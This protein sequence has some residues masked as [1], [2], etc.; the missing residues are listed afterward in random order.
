M[1]RK[2][3]M[4]TPAPPDR[5]MDG[6]WLTAKSQDEYWVRAQTLQGLR[7]LQRETHL[8][9]ARCCIGRRQGMQ[10]IND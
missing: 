1:K 6:V 3:V 4:E 9:A 10:F 8:H 2:G 5:R 7:Q